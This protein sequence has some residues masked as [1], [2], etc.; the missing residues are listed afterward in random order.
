[1]A[2]SQDAVV[3]SW[4]T[5]VSKQ[6]SR[7]TDVYGMISEHIDA[8]VK[9]KGSGPWASISKEQ[10]SV[11]GQRGLGSLLGEKRDRLIVRWGDYK[12]YVCSRPYGT[13]LDVSWN[14]TFEPGILKR[15]TTIDYSSLNAFQ[16]EDL[17]AFT[18]LVHRAVTQSVDTIMQEAGLDT[19]KVNKTSKGFL[20]VS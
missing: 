10:A 7:Y 14:L 6:A 11:A 9:V 17:R 12:I 3:D 13:D 8:V 20:G 4:G 18:T 5:L 16:V 15:M 19:E 1:M 2:L